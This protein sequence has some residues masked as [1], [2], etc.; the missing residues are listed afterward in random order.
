MDTFEVEDKFGRK[1]RLT[2]ER[3]LHITEKHPEI[4]DQEGK[5]KETLKKPELIKKSV[6]SGDV[7]LFYKYYKQTPVTGKY[8]AVGIKLL[9]SKG[10]VVTVYFTDRIKK[11]DVI[12][13]GK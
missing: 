13:M 3:R 8:L 9:N 5:I 12:W 10:F 7:L 11:G 4:G 1:I 6:Y 2:D